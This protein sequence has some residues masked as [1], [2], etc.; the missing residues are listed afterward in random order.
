M[1]EFKAVLV[2]LGHEV[3]TEVIGMYRRD[4]RKV[5]SSNFPSESRAHS[6]SPALFGAPRGKCAPDVQGGVRLGSV[7][8]GSSRVRGSAV[9]GASVF[10]AGFDLTEV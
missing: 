9:Y 4:S 10:V 5:P 2:G 8:G 1:S 3:P 7:P 6:V